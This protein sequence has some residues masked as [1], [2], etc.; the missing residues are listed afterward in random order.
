MKEHDLLKYLKRN[1]GKVIPELAEFSHAV[2][3]P[4]YDE[5]ET[6]PH[7]LENL[8]AVPVSEPTAVIVVVNYPSGADDNTSTELYEKLLNTELD[9]KIKLFP[10]FSPA[11]KNGVGEARKIGFDIFCRSR[12]AENADSSVIF[13]LD[14][15]CLIHNDYFTETLELLSQNDCGCAA[16]R[17]AHR[18]PDDPVLAEAIELYEKYLFDYEEN[19]AKCRSPYAY[20]AIGSGFAVKVRDYIRCGG[21][22]LKK[23]GEDFCFMQSVAKCSKIAK[24]SKALVYP[25]GRI[26][27]RVPFGTGTAVRDIMKGIMPRQVTRQAFD[28]L[29]KVLEI[30]DTPCILD[31]GE[32]FLS[33]LPE[34]SAAFFRTNGFVQAWSSIISNQ[35]PC[36]DKE[37]Q[38]AFHLW[39]DALQTRRFLHQ[40]SE[41]SNI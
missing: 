30:L 37:K 35:K 1:P 31:D 19:L 14:A 22:K 33:A 21:M 3:I 18:I 20:N 24:T 10:V 7:L 39:F 40:L 4:A 8:S 32:N 2:V 25:S 36:G 26:S 6:L 12:N 29:K 16:I 5:N 34:A 27:E 13:S 28:E 11:L 23:A 41:S 38:D 17:V 9:G 15:D